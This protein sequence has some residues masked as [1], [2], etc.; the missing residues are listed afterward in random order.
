MR[1]PADKAM[2]RFE[3]EREPLLVAEAGVPYRAVP[4][5]PIAAWFDLMELVGSLAPELPAPAPKVWGDYRL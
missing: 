4:D 2:R 1:L 5:D 3:G